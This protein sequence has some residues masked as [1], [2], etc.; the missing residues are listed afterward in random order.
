MNEAGLTRPGGAPTPAA[1]RRAKRVSIGG[2]DQPFP[3]Y[4]TEPVVAF[5]AS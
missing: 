4:D 2:L 5:S 3:N 1:T